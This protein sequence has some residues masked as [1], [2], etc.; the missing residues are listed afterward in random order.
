MKLTHWTTLLIVAASSTA[1]FAAPAKDRQIENAAKASYNYRTVLAD[2]VKVKANDGIV[3]L[4][5]TV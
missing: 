4:T 3:T 2:N 5:G 1:L